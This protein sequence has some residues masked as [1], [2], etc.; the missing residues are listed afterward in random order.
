MSSTTLIAGLLIGGMG[1]GEQPEPADPDTPAVV[2][3]TATSQNIYRV[4]EDGSMSYI[5]VN[6]PH[7]TAN[8]IYSWGDVLIDEKYKNPDLR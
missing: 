8:G 4:Y 6:N 2:G 3:I 1:G 7:R 5:K